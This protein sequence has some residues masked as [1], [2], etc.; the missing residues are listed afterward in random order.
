MKR[1]P[2]K[3]LSLQKETLER[4]GDQ[5]LEQFVVG[6]S[7]SVPECCCS[8]PSGCLTETGTG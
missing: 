5:T 4:L 7:D 8:K 6:G 1:K 2:L 3:K